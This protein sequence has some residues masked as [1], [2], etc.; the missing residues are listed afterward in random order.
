[1]NINIKSRSGK[2]T[3]EERSY[4]EQ[5]LQKLQRYTDGI[6]SITVELSRGQQRGA[7]E[8]HIAQATLQAEHGLLVRAEER[9]GEFTATI[10]ALHDRLQRQLTRYKDRHFRRGHVRGNNDQAGM[11]LLGDDDQAT[12]SANGNGHST[13][14]LVRTKQFSYKPMTSEEAI[15]QMELLSHD[16][17]IFT[18][19][20]RGQVSVVYRRKDGNYG[21]IE[22]DEVEVEG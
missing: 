19:A 20:D 12:K 5:K 22:Q 8:T 11:T 17:F 7:G 2:L 13:P 4:L 10:D 1:M 21:L 3:D 9:S 6:G 14:R 18:S 16:F 15:E